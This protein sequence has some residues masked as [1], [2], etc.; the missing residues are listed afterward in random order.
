MK[1]VFIVDDHTAIRE[2]FKAIL[3]RSQRYVSDGEA[4]SAE[5]AFEL[6]EREAVEPE[7][8]IVDVSLPGMS[9]L[10]FYVETPQNALESGRGHQ[11]AS[12]VRLHRRRFPRR[13][14]RLCGQR[15]GRGLRHRR[16]GRGGR[17]DLL[18]RSEFLEALHRRV[19]SRTLPAFVRP[20]RRI[21][22][23]GSRT[24]RPPPA[25]GRQACRGDSPESRASQ[26]TVENHLS[27]ITGKLGAR[28]RFELY[29]MAA[30]LEGV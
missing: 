14:L 13:R 17:G 22:A 2:G 18:P 1:K 27:I 3:E 15:R 29:R 30:R 28:D 11:H 26:K 5:E 4:S 12:A 6:L 25:F 23:F 8:L 21:G 24:G 20:I 9:G 7:L 19:G 16:P 10:D